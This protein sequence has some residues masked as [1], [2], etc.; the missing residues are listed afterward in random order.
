MDSK[1]IEIF[2]KFDKICV[3]FFILMVLIGGMNQNFALC[4]VGVLGFIF[5]MVIVHKDM[6]LGDKNDG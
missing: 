3:A 2:K 6:K 4:G 5:F 1:K